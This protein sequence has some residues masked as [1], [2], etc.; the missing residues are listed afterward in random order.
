MKVE[1]NSNCI[2]LVI[3]G[4][5]PF[6][7]CLNLKI[8]ACLSERI[9]VF[10]YIE[11]RVIEKFLLS[12]YRGRGSR[13][14]VFSG[15]FFFSFSVLSHEFFSKFFVHQFIATSIL[16]FSWKVFLFLS[17]E[18]WVTA[19]RQKKKKC[20]KFIIYHLFL[21]KKGESVIDFLSLEPKLFLD[22]PLR[23]PRSIKI[24]V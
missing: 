16:S 17:A 1:Q 19:R 18:R 11:K 14:L 6:D 2:D 15:S 5:L 7:D 3:S 12:Y 24:I 20:K 4:F 13:N 8:T 22:N 9:Q 23:Y 10:R 21:N